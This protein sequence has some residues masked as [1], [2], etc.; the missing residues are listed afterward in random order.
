MTDAEN[1]IWN[2]FYSKDSEAAARHGHQLLCLALSGLKDFA[3]HRH[4]CEV[5][6]APDPNDMS[7]WRLSSDWL[8]KYPIHVLLLTLMMS[9]VDEAIKDDVLGFFKDNR[10]EKISVAHEKDQKYIWIVKV[11][12]EK[13]DY[14]FAEIRRG[15]SNA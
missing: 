3:R 10:L 4:N 7:V 2:T 14:A 1:K 5:Y 15:D 12:G 6:R 11:K 8:R 13:Y 9:D